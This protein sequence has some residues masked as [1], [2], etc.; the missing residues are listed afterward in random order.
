VSV[1]ELAD[2]AQTRTTS[3]IVIVNLFRVFMVRLL[4]ASIEIVGST[5]NRLLTSRLP[6]AA[7]VHKLFSKSGRHPALA[8]GKKS[9]I[10]GQIFPSS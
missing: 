5:P 6:R 2:S 10:R 8:L 1:G 4:L 3:A 9:L 7:D